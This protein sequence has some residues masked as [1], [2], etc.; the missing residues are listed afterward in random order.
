MAR[1][2]SDEEAVKAIAADTKMPLETV[3]RMYAET[4]AEY[5]EGARITDYMPVLVAKRVRSALKQA[6]RDTAH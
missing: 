3:S 6:A 5:S 2:S 4:W 1:P